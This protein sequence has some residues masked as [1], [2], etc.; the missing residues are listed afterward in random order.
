MR[1]TVRS[2]AK[3]DTV[4]EAVAQH[5]ASDRLTFHSADLTSDAGWAEALAGVDVV[6]HV[7]SPLG[8]GRVT[9]PEDLVR[10]AREGAVRVL[11]APRRYA[12]GVEGGSAAAT[13]LRLAPRGPR[14]RIRFS[15]R[16]SAF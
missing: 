13:I 5:T 16:D 10:P 7:S 6:L 14:G 15:M 8:G 1:T 4:R 12:P 11:D 2:L 3:A 9:G